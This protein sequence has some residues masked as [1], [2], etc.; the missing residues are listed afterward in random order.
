MAGRLVDYIGSG[1]DAALPDP[2]VIDFV[3]TPG[4]GGIYYA[5]DTSTVY[6]LDRVAVAWDTI[7]GGGGVPGG[8]TTQIQF[9]NAGAFDGDADFAYDVTN[10]RMRGRQASFGDANAFNA[11]PTPGD[12]EHWLEIV[13]GALGETPG[14]QLFRMLGY[15]GNLGYGNNIHF[16]RADGTEATPTAVPDVCYLLSI[17]FRG[18]NGTQMSSSKAAFQ[19]ITTEAWSGTNNGCKFRFELTANGSTTR[20]LAAELTSGGFNVVGALNST[21]VTLTDGA[22]ISVDASLGNSFRVVLGGNRA[23]ANPTNLVDGQGLLFRIKQD[24]TGSRTLSYGSKYKFPGGAPTLSTAANALDVISCQ[25]DATDDTLICVM[26]NDF[27]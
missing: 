24:T 13:N 19:V 22:T 20:V 7:T 4:A 2:A 11:N 5:T 14:K 18:Y 27:S 23:L 21:K 25:Y 1:L 6:V 12:D 15:G 17:G 26:Q 9:N 10:Q 16:E 8:S 3:L